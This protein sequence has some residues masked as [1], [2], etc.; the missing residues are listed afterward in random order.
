MLNRGRPKEAGR[1]ARLALSGPGSGLVHHRG[2]PGAR[3]VEENRPGFRTQHSGRVDA[4]H[5]LPPRGP[6]GPVRR[7][8]LPPLGIVGGLGAG[9]VGA[10]GQ[11]G[12][13]RLGGQPEFRVPRLSGP[14]PAEHQNPARPARAASRAAR[15]RAARPR[16]ARPRAARRARARRRGQDVTV[17]RHD[18]APELASPGQ[19][20]LGGDT[21]IGVQHRDDGPSV[22]Q[23]PVTERA[24]LR[25]VLQQVEQH[26]V[27]GPRGIRLG[28]TRPDAVLFGATGRRRW[29]LPLADEQSAAVGAGHGPASRPSLDAI[30]GSVRPGVGGPP[31]VD[32]QHAVH[33]H[34][35]GTTSA[36][37]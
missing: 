21:V 36:V 2:Q 37:G 15:P 6:P 4:L 14:R 10:R 9:R 20:L 23:A 31:G 26:D 19:F 24:E 17:V 8:P 11:I 28:G 3:P 12:H 27:V 18:D 7:H 33:Q 32:A 1:R 25:R 34:S 30:P 29:P 5:G 35:G 16:A 22:H 13:L